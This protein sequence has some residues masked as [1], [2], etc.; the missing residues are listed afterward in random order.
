MT[1]RLWL[2]EPGR[3]TCLAKVTDVRGV[4]FTVDRAL[5]APQSRACR[6]PQP[7]DKGT[8]WIA[9]EKRRLEAIRADAG[10][11]W[12]RLRGTTPAVGAT[13]QCELDPDW[14]DAMARGHT[15]MHL[16]IAA[17]DSPMTADPEV[18][19]D[20]H[21]RLT[22]QEFLAPPRIEGWLQ[23]VRGWIEADLPLASRYVEHAEAQRF[24]TP[25]RFHPPNPVPGDVAALVEISGVCAYPCDG[26]HVDRTGRIGEVRLVHAAMGKE[27]FVVV[28]R[29]S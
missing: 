22:F 27:G 12:Y 18:R 15:L 17:S 5:F 11:V 2:T 25:Q 28:V 7:A 9:G 21:A 16:V 3:A 29:A 13:L 6:H 23:R 4:W 8:V 19:G 1:E 20:G 26:R 24:A 10:G 14:R